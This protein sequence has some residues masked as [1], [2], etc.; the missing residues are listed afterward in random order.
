MLTLLGKD[1]IVFYFHFISYY[2]IIKLLSY[3][4]FKK[5][6][7]QKK[8]CIGS[9]WV[10]KSCCYKFISTLDCFASNHTNLVF[11]LTVLYSVFIHKDQQYLLIK[12]LQHQF[13]FGSVNNF[14]S[15]FWKIITALLC[16]ILTKFSLIY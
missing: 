9:I 14:I 8:K 2:S 6:V 7:I 11:F 15:Q 12:F 4:K 1:P 10:T 3:N 13:S 5:T 16:N